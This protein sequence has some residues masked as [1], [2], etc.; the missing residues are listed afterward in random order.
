MYYLWARTYRK[1]AEHLRIDVFDPKRPMWTNS[2]RVPDACEKTAL[3]YE[4]PA[5]ERKRVLNKLSVLITKWR[6]LQG[7]ED[8]IFHYRNVAGA[9]VAKIYISW[10]ASNGM[11]PTVLNKYRHL[12]EPPFVEILFRRYESVNNIWNPIHSLPTKAIFLATDEH[13]PDSEKLEIALET[14]RANQNCLV[15]FFAR[16]HGKQKVLDLDAIDINNDH[17]ETTASGATPTGTPASLFPQQ[18]LV[19]EHWHWSYN[20]TS[21]RRPRPYSLVSANLMLLSSDFLFVYTCLLPERIHR[22]IDEQAE[23]GADLAM[24][25]LVSGM[26]GNRPILV[27]SE[28]P[29]DPESARYTEGFASARAQLLKDLVRLFTGGLKDPLQYNSVT[30]AQFNKIPFKKRSAKQWNHV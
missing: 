11:P 25:L 29:Y 18:S 9:I 24:N 22:F 3:L 26:T 14:W 4:D 15:G 19:D 30:V 27:K 6:S 20:L 5:H 13:L 8:A 21:I 23:D 16:Y 7:L 2:K 1:I 17:A 10:N 28:F 12:K